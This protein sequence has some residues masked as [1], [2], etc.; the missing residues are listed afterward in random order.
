MRKIFFLGFWISVSL[1]L[2]LLGWTYYEDKKPTPPRTIQYTVPSL[3]NKSLI[4]PVTITTETAATLSLMK[5]KTFLAPNE[6]KLI[7]T[8][9]CTCNFEN[10]A[11]EEACRG[12]LYPSIMRELNHDQCTF[13]STHKV[14]RFTTKHN[15]ST[16]EKLDTFVLLLK[17]FD[18]LILLTKFYTNKEIDYWL[19]A[20]S[21]LG[22]FC[23]KGPL[24]KDV[25]VDVGMLVPDF[26]LLVSFLASNP[27]IISS[28]IQFVVRTGKHSDV[29]LAKFINITN[30]LYIDVAAFYESTTSDNKKTLR[31]KHSNGRCIGCDARGL[32]VPIEMVFPTYRCLFGDTYVNCP[33]ETE[34]ICRKLF[35]SP[36]YE[37]PAEYQKKKPPFSFGGRH[38]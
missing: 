1:Y 32:L 5:N 4:S 19:Y 21:L 8:P 12:R 7:Q 31:Q 18:F 6:S 33:R 11:N 20:G 25:D 27:S 29:I 22:Q 30:G 36:F 24:P 2:F 15:L 14:D 16:S 37:C 28:H 13:V 38:A 23:Y 9:D 34:K 17:E 35:R 10:L 26:H 3:D